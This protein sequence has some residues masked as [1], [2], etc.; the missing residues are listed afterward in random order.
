MQPC[1]IDYSDYLP[2]S[3]MFP[4]F[5]FKPHTSIINEAHIPEQHDV[6]S[7]IFE[8]RV[9]AVMSAGAHTQC[10][11]GWRQR[12]YTHIHTYTSCSVTISILLP[13]N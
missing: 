2:L 3:A 8:G 11:A 5:F 1:L 13:L 6:S 7:G 4:P 9:S 12:V 10:L